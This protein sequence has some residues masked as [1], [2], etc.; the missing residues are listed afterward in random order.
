LIDNKRVKVKLPNKSIHGYGVEI[1]EHGG[2]VIKL[3]DG[4]TQIITSGEVK[5]L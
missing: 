1:N 4:Q 2:L 5:I 3:D